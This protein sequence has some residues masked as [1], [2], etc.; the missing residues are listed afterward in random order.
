M[1]A[2]FE[3]LDMASLIGLIR[4]KGLG[5]TFLSNGLGLAEIGALTG[6]KRDR[7]D[8]I[9]EERHHNRDLRVSGRLGTDRCFGRPPFFSAPAPP[10]A[11]GLRRWWRCELNVLVRNL[12]ARP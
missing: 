1:R 11:G 2:S 3:D 6:V 10:C 8:G 7:T 4:E 9:A 5:L 12:H